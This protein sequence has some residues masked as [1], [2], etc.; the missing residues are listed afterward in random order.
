MQ[1]IRAEKDS[2]KEELFFSP[3]EG[4]LIVVDC[5]GRAGSSVAVSDH[6]T[7]LLWCGSEDI[8]RRSRRD[9]RHSGFPCTIGA[10]PPAG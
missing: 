2:Q 10:G 6:V 4:G 3:L 5:G 1:T 7:L 9:A 8:V